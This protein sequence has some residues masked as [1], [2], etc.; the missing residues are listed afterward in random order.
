MASAALFTLL[1]ASPAHAVE[2]GL[3][4]TAQ[5]AEISTT[6]S[7]ELTVGTIIQQALGLVGVIFLILMVVAGFMWMTAGGNDRRGHRN[8]H[9]LLLLRHHADGFPGP[10]Y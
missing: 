8:D 7:I 4:E 2:T 3:R 1:S 10:R 6:G 9:H 5:A